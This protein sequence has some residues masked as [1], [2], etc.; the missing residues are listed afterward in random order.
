MVAFMRIT[1]A[2][3]LVKIHR[4]CLHIGATDANVPT[5]SFLLIAH[6]ALGVRLARLRPLQYTARITV[7][8]TN[9]NFTNNNGNDNKNNINDDNS[10]TVEDE[11]FVWN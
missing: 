1:K 7:T 10:N 11:I 8:T 4:I 9:Y 5:F 3:T 2:H 6:I